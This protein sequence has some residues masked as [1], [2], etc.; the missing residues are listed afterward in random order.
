MYSKVE[1]CLSAV[2]F[3]S[4]S[5]W[6]Y[7]ILSTVRS[8]PRT[9]IENRPTNGWIRRNLGFISDEN[10]V[11]VAITRAKKGLFLIGMLCPNK[12]QFYFF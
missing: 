7:V 6:D 4:G 2:L 3:F 5:E 12:Q 8:L 9:Q 11:N 1:K 10:Q